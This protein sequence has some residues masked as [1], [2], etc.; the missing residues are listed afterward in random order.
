MIIL[1]IFVI[2][3]INIVVIIFISIDQDRSKEI[4]DPTSNYRSNIKLIETNH[5]CYGEITYNY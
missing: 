5:L 2:T 4:P 3:M 1:I